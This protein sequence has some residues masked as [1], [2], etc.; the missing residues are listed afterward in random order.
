MEE[1]NVHLPPVKTQHYT[2][3]LHIRKTIHK[4]I[5]TYI[6][7]VGDEQRPCLEVLL[8]NFTPGYEINSRRLDSINTAHLA[9]VKSLE[10]CV[11]DAVSND[12]Y[13]EHSIGK[14]LLDYIIQL[15][16]RVS[17]IKHLTLSDQ[18]Q[19]PCNR[20]DPFDQLDLLLYSV[21][22]YGETWYERF[23]NAYMKKPSDYERYKREVAHY[24]SPEFK[25]TYDFE[26]FYQ[27]I[28]NMKNP[29]TTKII[30]P[31][32]E[33]VKAYYDSS[34]T[35]PKF[36]KKLNTIIPRK[37]KCRFYNTWLTTFISTNVH[38]SRDWVIDL[39]STKI[40]RGGTRSL[41]KRVRKTVKRK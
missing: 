25:R 24:I 34:D 20:K 27:Y 32:Y 17:H 26:T 2:F 39:Y 31:Q 8:H 4:E 33:T 15:L 9:N 1:Y 29:F 30:D 35:F 23:Y 11:E 38:I 37:D 7:L 36:F 13:A 41:R 12:Y 5:T 28:M 6:I 16:K 3:H 19:I 22:M 10:E 18:S 21:A 14:E 40:K